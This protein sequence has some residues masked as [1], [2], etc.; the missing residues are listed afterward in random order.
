MKSCASIRPLRHGAPRRS[1]A[2]CPMIRH[3]PLFAA[4][5]EGDSLKGGGHPAD[6]PVPE[7]TEIDEMSGEPVPD[8][9]KIPGID[10]PG[11][12]GSKTHPLDPDKEPQRPG[13]HPVDPLPPRGG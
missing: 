9:G 12:P 5:R 3:Q 1:V 8:R 13:S 4:E 11:V 7:S 10:D 6:V 2:S